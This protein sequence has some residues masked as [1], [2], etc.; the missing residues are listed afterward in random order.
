[1]WNNSSLSIGLCSYTVLEPT[2]AILEPETANLETETTI[3]EPEPEILEPTAPTGMNTTRLEQTQ[4]HKYN[5]RSRPGN[6]NLMLNPV[7]YSI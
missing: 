4:K 3:M 7:K 5:L 2:P 6:K 1:M